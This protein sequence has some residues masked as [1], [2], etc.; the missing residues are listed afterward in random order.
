M[1]PEL[2]PEE[3]LSDGRASYLRNHL[4]SNSSTW[5]CNTVGRQ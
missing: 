4:A 3:V 1:L 5:A 2:S